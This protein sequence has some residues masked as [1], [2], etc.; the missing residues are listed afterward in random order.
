MLSIIIPAYNEEGNIDPLFTRLTQVIR[1]IRS[2]F[3]LTV[4]VIV[5][6]NRSTDRTLDELRNFAERH[7]GSLFD[8][9]I[10]RFARNIGF[11]R[12]ILVGYCKARGDAVV[13]LDADLQDPPELLCEFVRKWHEGYKVVYGVRRTR[14]ESMLNQAMRKTFYRAL[15]WISEDDLPH[16]AGDFRLVDRSLVDVICSLR[17]HDPYLRGLIANLGLRQIGIPYDR[18]ARERGKSK[19]GFLQLAKL[20][21][22]GITNHSALPLRL[23]S[24]IAFGVVVVVALMI[25]Y[26]LGG[27]L[28]ANEALPGGFITQ[29]LLQLGSLAT[30]SFLIGI[31]GFYIHRIYNQVK[32]RPLAIIEYNFQKRAGWPAGHETT[33]PVEVLWVGE[34]GGDASDSAGHP[35]SSASNEIRRSYA[36]P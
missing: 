30:L 15:D 2:E 34:S 28:F 23:A 5:N 26:Y 8:L 22:D 17:D 25:A 1:G 7:D 4:E 21:V 18:T 12:S 29:T 27:W 35:S 20:A 31:Q 11:Q 13:Q 14:K 3:G 10:F 6:D 9:R 16:D 24:Y 33:D 19:F 32:E 36:R